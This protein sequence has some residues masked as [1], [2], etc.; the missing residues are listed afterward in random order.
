[1]GLY[2]V[3]LGLGQIIGSLLGGVAADL[4]GIDGIII[5]T[6]LLLG[7]ALIP[8][9]RLRRFEHVV[10]GGPEGRVELA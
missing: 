1:M 5:G 2:S 9:A 6:L 4:R 8:L 7:I 3:F 10:Q